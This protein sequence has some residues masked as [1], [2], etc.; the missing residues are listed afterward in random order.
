MDFEFSVPKTTIQTFIATSKSKCLSWYGGA[1]EQTA[2]V[3]AYCEGT[4][5]MEAY[6]G[7]C[8]ETY[9]AIKMMSFMGSPWLLD[10]DNASSHSR[11]VLQQ[12]G[13]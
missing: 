11:H 6:I 7:D 13:S 4:I 8:T 3:T 5:D 10:Q 9:T 2:W 1:A 12:R